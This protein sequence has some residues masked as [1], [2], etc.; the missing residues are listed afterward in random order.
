MSRRS[1]ATSHM[2]FPM[3][4]GCIDPH[5][6]AHDRETRCSVSARGWN[7][8]GRG[9]RGGG[10]RAY[11]AVRGL[12]DEV[13]GVA[14]DAEH[15]A[16]D[17]ERQHGLQPLQPRH[18]RKPE[19]GGGGGRGSATAARSRGGGRG[20]SQW[21]DREMVCVTLLGVVRVE[22]VLWA[23]LLGFSEMMLSLSNCVGLYNWTTTI[24]CRMGS[25]RCFETLRATT[26][27]RADLMRSDCP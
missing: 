10:T 11:P 26:A 22:E 4:F 2:S 14:H 16:D 7:R 20:V 24:P 9:W 27:T 15:A 12:V 3:C 21:T 5:T 19:R 25:I 23:G 18:R 17:A 1:M 13:L 6:H 8:I